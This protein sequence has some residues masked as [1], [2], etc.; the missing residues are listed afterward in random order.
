ML[1]QKRRIIL[2]SRSR[3][4]RKILRE[5][6][7]KMGVAYADIDESR[8]TGE[9]VQNYVLRVAYAKAEKIASL[10]RNAVV[11]GVDTVIASGNRIFGKPKN[12]SEATSILRA[13][14]GRQHK[15]YTGIVVIDSANGR[16][17]KRLVASRVKFAKLNSRQI[18]WYISTGEPFTV[19]GA[20]SIQGKGR[21]LIE[22]VGG[23][24]TSIIGISIPAF[25]K[26]LK[27]LKAV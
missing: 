22:S 11:V 3:A 5:C 16:T 4:R 19:A 17:I 7:L 21:A 9:C 13:L 12:K 15:V 8:R 6:G 26:M 27:I 24:F 25:A 10:S 2:A 20:Y 1:F 14:S 18:D 23:C